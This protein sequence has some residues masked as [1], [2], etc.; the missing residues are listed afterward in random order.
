VTDRLRSR[1]TVLRGG[2]AAALATRVR[3]T[4]AQTSAPAFT[5]PIGLPDRPLGD[6]LFI[7]HGY[8]TENTWYN[9][10]RLKNQ[11]RPED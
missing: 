11:F 9:P 10:G 5:L 7:R 1:R 8:A 3:P 2:L 4:S 6:G